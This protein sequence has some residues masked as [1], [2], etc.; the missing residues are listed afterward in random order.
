MPV[1][2]VPIQRSLLRGGDVEAAVWASGNKYGVPDLD[3]TMQ[4]DRLIAPVKLWGS[5]KRTEPNP[6]SWLFYTADY[7]F[8][9]LWSD[10]KPVVNSGALVAAEPNFSCYSDTPYA[11][12]LWRIY[13]KRWLARFWQS[14]GIYVLVDLNVHQRFAKLNLLGV[15]SGWRGFVTRGYLG[16]IEQTEREYQIAC[17][18]ALP[19][20][21]FF[22]VYG[23]SQRLRRVCEDRNWHWIPERADCVKAMRNV[24]V[25]V[26]ANRREVAAGG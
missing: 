26:R 18:Q 22:V 3:I 15:P 9:A 2:A 16:N 14:Q 13:Q 7:R 19:N 1:T 11:V 24:P 5:V 6:G 20:S 21:P 25:G 4:A 12:A 17:N 23:G 8:S 10:P